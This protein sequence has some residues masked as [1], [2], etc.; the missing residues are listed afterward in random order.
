M[1]E[2]DPALVAALA[3]TERQ[4][5][6]L[7][8]FGGKDLTEQVTS[9]SLD[10]AYAT[11]LPAPMRAVQGSAAAEL[12]L[13]LSGDGEQTATQ[14]YSPYAPHATSDIVRPRQS[15]VHGWGLDT[16]VL[17]AFRGSVRDRAADSATGTVTVSAL[18]AAERLRDAARLPVTV[19][20]T[21]GSPISSGVWVVDHLL[22]N[23]GIHSAP[24]PREDCILYASLHGGVTPDIGFYR[25]HSGVTGY[26]RTN[27]PWEMAPTTSNEYTIRW[28]PRTRTTVPGRGLFMETW[29]DTTS[30]AASGKFTLMAFYQADG[31]TNQ[32]RMIVDFA[33]DEVWLGTNASV[34]IFTRPNISGRGR[35]HIGVYWQFDGLQP[36][37]W[38]YLSGPGNP[39]T[40]DD[41]SLFDPMPRSNLNYVQ[42]TSGV[43]CEAVQVSIRNSPPTQAEFEQQG[44]TR[45]A[46]LDEIGS[47]LAAIPPVNGSAWDVI[48]DVAQAEQA[49]AEF[50]ALGIFRWRTN[51]RFLNPSFD[52]VHVA[53]SEREIASIKVFEAI[54]NVR[55][56]VDV[57]YQTYQPGTAALRFTEPR[58]QQ[59]PNASLSLTYEYDVTEYD[60]APPVVYV[61]TP[62][63]NTS[64][65]R[66]A[67]DLDGRAG[68]HGAVETTVERDGTKLTVTFRNVLNQHLVLVTSGGASSLAIYSTGLAQ[69]S[70]SRMSWRSTDNPSR[71]RY[72][73]Q[74]YQVPA[75]PWIQTF[76]AA[77]RVANYLLSVASAPLPTLGDVEILPDPRIE[78]G[79]LVAVIDNVGARLSLLAWVVGIR[80][81][82]DN[83]GSIKQILSLRAIDSPGPPTDTGL[84]PDPLLDPGARA[85]LLREGIR[86]P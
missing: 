41:T 74:V 24:P 39:Y 84:S 2:A 46:V 59:I 58:V 70:P 56:V 19:T 80:L 1:L 55:N 17:P 61:T 82:G 37:A 5:T 3:A 60:S 77:R 47:E 23:A 66:F 13:T 22:R 4:N 18:D 48:T 76:Q 65:V 8:R 42:L 54:D 34:V 85:R 81:S 31:A 71:A 7:T 36:R 25:Q 21:A 63:E 11:D 15:A 6:T 68:V 43:P 33:R 64:R 28:D 9:W 67:T 79:D 83:T 35:W 50:D 16:S 27:V 29:A 30:A 44:W 10:R 20:A 14:L 86:V 73:P 32:V 53:T 51:R 75:T 52:K 72:G 38:L 69:R 62:P 40:V 45:G 78:L 57:P 12:R 49:T 26:T